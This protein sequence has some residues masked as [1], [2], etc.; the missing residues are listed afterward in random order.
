M[1]PLFA[2]KRY[3]SRLSLDTFQSTNNQK[4]HDLTQHMEKTLEQL[5]ANL[6]VSQKAQKFAANF[7]STLVLA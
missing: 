2:N 3:H 7:H 6:L 5:K 1:T 4:A